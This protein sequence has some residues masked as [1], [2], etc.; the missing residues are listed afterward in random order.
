MLALLFIIAS[1]GVEVA[2]P[3]TLDVFKALRKEGL[4]VGYPDGL[5]SRPI[6]IRYEG[7]VATHAT[8]SHV[9]D[10]LTDFAKLDVQSHS[11]VYA[12]DLRSIR[13]FTQHLYSLERL[14]IAFH[15]ELSKME[16]EIPLEQIRQLP[17]DAL[18]LQ[19][20]LLAYPFTR[21]P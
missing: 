4:L 5:H 10:I 2:P 16:S 17:I 19:V 6:P 13:E 7:A 3:W 9:R 21:R 1:S 20:R 15:P 12:R 18:A 8:I 11:D 14:Y